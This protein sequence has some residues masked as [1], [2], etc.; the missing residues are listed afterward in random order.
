VAN[1]LVRWIPLTDTRDR[2]KEGRDALEAAKLDK[3]QDYVKPGRTAEQKARDKGTIEKI[4]QAIDDN[5]ATRD[6]AN[7]KKKKK[8]ERGPEDP[9][10]FDP[11]GRY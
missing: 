4:D 5:Q 9:F 3:L 8:K 1:E 10:T 2:L 6:E 11:W 7:D